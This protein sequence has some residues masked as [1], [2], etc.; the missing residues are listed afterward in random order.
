MDLASSA[1]PEP[2]YFLLDPLLLGS[3]RAQVPLAP[4][5]SHFSASLPSFS[6]LGQK[7]NHQTWL[8]MADPALTTSQRDLWP[9][10]QAFSLIRPQHK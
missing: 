4:M 8:T 5:S 7:T 3:I 10:Y 9:S 6:S 1:R 2:H